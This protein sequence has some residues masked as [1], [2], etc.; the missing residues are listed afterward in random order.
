MENKII[1]AYVGITGIR[2][3]DISDYVEKIVMKIMPRSIDAEVI[4]IPVQSF[5]TRIEC[6]NPKY[7]TDADLIN[8]HQELMKKINEQLQFQLDELKQNKNEQKT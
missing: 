7:I 2:S 1:V 5:D 8:E 6:I 4:G 3:E